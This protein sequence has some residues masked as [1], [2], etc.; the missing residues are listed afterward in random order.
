MKA[1][2]APAMPSAVISNTTRIRRSASTRSSEAAPPGGRKSRR[3]V[4]ASSTAARTLTAATHQ[5]VARQPAWSATTTP[6]GT[7]RIVERLIPMITVATAEP[8]RSGG[9]SLPAMTSATANSVQCA[10]AAT[11]RAAISRG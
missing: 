7:P 2:N 3:T 6:T 9:T 11:T 1:V 8:A 5:N 4:S 10:R